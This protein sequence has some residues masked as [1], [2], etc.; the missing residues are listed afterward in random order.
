MC[1]C[2]STAEPQ[3]HMI[4]LDA[5]SGK[6]NFAIE[7][8]SSQNTCLFLPKIAGPHFPLDSD[9]IPWTTQKL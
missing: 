5:M 1:V 4:M 2:Q 8:C 9:Y 6:V 7:I 3:Y